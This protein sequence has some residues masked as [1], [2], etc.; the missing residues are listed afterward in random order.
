MDPHTPTSASAR[1]DHETDHEES[2]VPSTFGPE[3]AMGQAQGMLQ[4]LVQHPE[5]MSLFLPALD[6][7][8]AM[9]Q[10]E[11]PVGLGGRSQLDLESPGH[12]QRPA[13]TGAQASFVQDIQK[14]WQA[15]DEDAA[16]EADSASGMMDVCLEAKVQ[17]IGRK[18]QCLRPAF[19]VIPRPGASQ[20]TAKRSKKHVDNFITATMDASSDAS[21]MGMLVLLFNSIAQRLLN[22]KDADFVLEAVVG[23]IWS[24]R[25]GGGKKLSGRS[26]ASQ[27]RARTVLKKFG[28]A[29]F[30][31]LSDFHFAIRSY[32]GQQV[33]DEQAAMIH[34]HVRPA[35]CICCVCCSLLPVCSLCVFFSPWN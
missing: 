35:C 26:P 29:A 32:M 5:V 18:R 13:S 31:S 19:D 17:V 23:V 20:K 22:V 4:L 8:L 15:A 1:S 2:D 9:M 24:R 34:T 25:Q 7:L 30:D 12:Q 27:H 14:A 11:T 16:A 6:R 33:P 3:E 10:V 28:S 21:A